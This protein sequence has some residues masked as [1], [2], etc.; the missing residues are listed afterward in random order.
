MDLRTFRKT[1]YPIFALADGRVTVVEERELKRLAKFFKIS[2]KAMKEILRDEVRIFKQNRK[3][4]PTKAVELQFRR[5]CKKALADG[6]VTPSEECELK[7]LAKF[8]NMST[9]VMKAI[10]ADEVRVF[11]QSNPKV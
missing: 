5:A 9:A 4:R 10:L 6:K 2:N 3:A 7:S 11:R 1:G 8:F